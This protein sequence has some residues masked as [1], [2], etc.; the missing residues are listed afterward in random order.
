MHSEGYNVRNAAN[1]ETFP[2]SWAGP[3]RKVIQREL[4]GSLTRTVD[5]SL[6]VTSTRQISHSDFL[7]SVSPSICSLHLPPRCLDILSAINYSLEKHGRLAW[8]QVRYYCTCLTAWVPWT[9]LVRFWARL[10]RG[11]CYQKLLTDLDDRLLWRDEQFW[12]DE[13]GWER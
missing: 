2:W 8:R 7:L 11:S 4:S 12:R 5:E 10:A 3:Q 9:R 1:V 6:P 13:R